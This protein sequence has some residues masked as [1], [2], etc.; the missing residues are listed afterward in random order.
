MLDPG[1]TRGHACQKDD[2]YLGQRLDCLLPLLARTNSQSLPPFTDGNA[3]IHF[4]Y[5]L[6]TAGDVDT[7]AAALQSQAYWQGA[8]RESSSSD[9]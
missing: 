1:S 4:R 8:I 2:L 6:G 7:P 9:W 3:R 5:V